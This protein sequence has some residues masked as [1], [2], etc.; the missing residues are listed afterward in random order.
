MSSNCT[1]NPNHA[2]SEELTTSPH[3]N[4]LQCTWRWWTG[5]DTTVVL[6]AVVVQMPHSLHTTV[7]KRKCTT[8]TTDHTI[9]IPLHYHNPYT[10]LCGSQL[11]ELSYH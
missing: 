8:S 6:S 2:N 11:T 3:K 10:L 9:T 7:I 5:N 4:W 1:N